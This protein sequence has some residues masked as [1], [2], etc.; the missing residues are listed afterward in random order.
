MHDSSPSAAS[1]GVIADGYF[2]IVPE[3]VLDAKISANA[4]K[5]YAILRRYADKGTSEAHPSRRTLAN[6]MGFTRPQSVDPII[7]ELATV[8]ALDVFERYT[9]RGD[10]DSNGYRLH[11]NPFGG[12]HTVGGQSARPVGKRSARPVGGQTA[13]NPES[14]EPESQEPENTPQSV[15]PHTTHSA[16]GS[17][18]GQSYSQGGDR[19]V[20]TARVIEH[21]SAQCGRDIDV[22]T[23]SEIASTILDRA[24]RY[25]NRATGYVLGAITRDP[26][27]WKSYI[28]TGKVPA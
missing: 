11:M 22:A 16:I 21:V 3:W 28:D 23:A 18:D 5:L 14:Q 7:T 25:P 2:A 10:R 13:H 26:F 6:R 8:G 1:P 9:D 15:P 17:T 4:C 24:K 19:F 27:G 12:A 20:E